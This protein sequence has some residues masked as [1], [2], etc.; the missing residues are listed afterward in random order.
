MPLKSNTMPVLSILAVVGIVFATAGIARAESQPKTSVMSE[1]NSDSGVLQR[2]GMIS[3]SGKGIIVAKIKRENRVRI[4]FF[5][6][7]NFGYTASFIAKNPSLLFG[8]DSVEEA[9]R[10]L[11]ANP[12]SSALRAATVEACIGGPGI[13]LNFTDEERRALGNIDTAGAPLV[14][15]VKENTPKPEEIRARKVDFPLFDFVKHGSLYWLDNLGEGAFQYRT[16]DGGLSIVSGNMAKVQALIRAEIDDDQQ[17]PKFLQIR[18]PHVALYFFGKR[19]AYIITRSYLEKRASVPTDRWPV[20][21]QPQDWDRSTGLLQ[22]YVVSVT[23]VQV[24]GGK[25]NL[26]MYVTNRDGSIEKWE[27]DGAVSPYSILNMKQTV[28]EKPGS[29]VPLP[30]MTKTK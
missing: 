15:S 5:A 7:G 4:V 19:E 26:G 6:A 28:C 20:G 2:W 1:A 21:V 12:P 18:F 30:L 11:Q 10:F 27:M 17:M 13:L 29:V 22:K 8:F 3:K 9:A 25:W 14:A 16:N 24:E 23:P